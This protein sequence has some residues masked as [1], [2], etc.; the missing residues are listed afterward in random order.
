[1]RRR[2]EQIAHRL[3]SAPLLRGLRVE[4]S[5]R[6]NVPGTGGVLLAANHQSFLDMFVLSA[7]SPRAPRFL[8][9]VEFTRGPLRRAVE[10]LGMVPVE[11]GRG[12]LAVVQTLADLLREGAAVG[13]F[14][15][16]TRSPDGRLYRFRSGLARAAA[17]AGVPTVP[18]SLR[19]TAQV[20]PKGSNPPLRR[21]PR[22]VLSVHFSEVIPPPQ[23]TASDRR[24]FTAKVAAAVA[25]QCDQP[26]ADAFA[27]IS[28]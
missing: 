1:M 17:D 4:V 18:V 25:A 27:P 28:A 8:G 11:R 13:I 5:G 16:G 9:K 20:W 3:T 24:A 2:P 15:E 6:G 14:P 23:D 21:P 7:A 19:G 22:G 10:L 12:D 26:G